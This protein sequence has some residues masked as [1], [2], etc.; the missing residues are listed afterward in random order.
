MNVK[1]GYDQFFI[2]EGTIRNSKKLRKLNMSSN[3]LRN[4]GCTEVANIM[5]SN[6]SIQT[7]N[8]DNND[9]KEHGL[10]AMLKV[11]ETNKTLVKLRME[12]NKFLVSRQLLGL[13]GNLFVFKNRTLQQMILTYHGQ[14][15]LKKELENSG[16]EFDRDMIIR[17][18][19]EMHNKTNLKLF[20]I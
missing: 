15:L 1:M 10:V 2:L 5:M 6:T 20:T 17:F 11:L 9:I 12:N 4:Q 3:Q 18:M 13:I 7:L 19:Q 14:A 16:D 8:L